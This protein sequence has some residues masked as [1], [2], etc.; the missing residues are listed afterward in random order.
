MALSVSLGHFKLL[1]KHWKQKNGFK[2]KHIMMR[3][4]LKKKITQVTVCLLKWREVILPV[5]KLG[6]KLLHKTGSGENLETF[7]FSVPA[8]FHL[9]HTQKLEIL[10]KHIRSCPLLRLVNG[11]LFYSA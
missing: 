10:S 9:S 4:T 6:R 8:L 11:P 2:R 5:R 3:M 7:F 1:S